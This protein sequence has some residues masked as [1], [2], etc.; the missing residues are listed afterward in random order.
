MNNGLI[1]YRNESY[2]LSDYIK[3]E[4]KKK[5]KDRNITI[6]LD[7]ENELLRGINI[8]VSDKPF[9]KSNYFK[10]SSYNNTAQLV[11][12]IFKVFSYIIAT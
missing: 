6:T 2:I 4:F 9:I 3:R 7:I 1:I 10:I 8:S 5:Y 11:N 12:S